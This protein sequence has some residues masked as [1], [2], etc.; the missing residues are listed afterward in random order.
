MGKNLKNH[1]S[2]QLKVDILGSDGRDQLN[3]QTLAQYVNFATGPLSST[4]LSQVGAMVKCN[5]AQIPN[6][7]VYRL[8]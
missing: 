5:N 6:L 4:G 1:V 2:Y 3:N 8:G 7:Q